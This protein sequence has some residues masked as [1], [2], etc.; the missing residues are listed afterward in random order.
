M[1]KKE[2]QIIVRRERYRYDINSNSDYSGLDALLITGLIIGGAISYMSGLMPYGHEVAVHSPQDLAWMAHGNRVF[3]SG[4]SLIITWRL[5]TWRFKNKAFF[6]GP[7]TFMHFIYKWFHRHEPL[8]PSDDPK[9][10][11][12]L[13]YTQP[14]KTN[15]ETVIF[16]FL[17]TKTSLEDK[18]VALEREIT[19]TE[20]ILNS[21]KEIGHQSVT[22]V[23]DILESQLKKLKKL[24][25]DV[26]QSSKK[27]E[28]DL[29]NIVG[30]FRNLNKVGDYVKSLNQ[31]EVNNYLIKCTEEIVA[32]AHSLHASRVKAISEIESS[33]A[34]TTNSVKELIAMSVPE[35]E[36][37]LVRA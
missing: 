11:L 34:L 30:K 28:A 24:Q 26:A 36:R 22:P 17:C 31:I 12:A 27:I 1:T 25:R 6:V 7:F 15:Q 10:T 23:V 4:I 32:E 9:M 21:V 35:E 37:A 33:I 20:D 8:P 29:D 3:F 14:N 19:S 13:L 16:E 18:S 2:A 5:I